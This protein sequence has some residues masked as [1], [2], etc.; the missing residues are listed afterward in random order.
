MTLGRK[1]AKFQ[2]AWYWVFVLILISGFP[3]DVE[4]RRIRVATLNLDN[5]LIADRRVEGG[6]RPDY[7]K[8]EARKSAL[9]A[10]ILATEA[11]ILA[12]QEMGTEPFLLELQRDLRLEGLDYPHTALMVGNDPDRHTAVLSKLPFR[13]VIRETELDFK[14]F[15]GRGLVKRGLLEVVFETESGLRWSLFNLHLKSRLETRSDD[16]ESN[17][18][19]RGEALAVR[20]VIRKKYPPE[21]N[22]HY[23]IVGDLNDSRNSPALRLLKKRGESILAKEIKA[24]DS[25]GEVWTYFYAKNE[26]YSRVDYILASPALFPM[27]LNEKGVVVDSPEMDAASDHRMVYADL[28]IPD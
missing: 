15:E 3:T 20:D 7:P 9:R 10:V 6:Y 11:D 24:H 26:E 27:F 18:R 8:P 21:E 1:S 22:H 14:Y 28:E 12:V 17:L 13:E 2:A 19:R 4:G 23:L 25:R 5:Y 16:I